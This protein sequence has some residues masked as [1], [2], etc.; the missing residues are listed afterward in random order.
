MCKVETKAAAAKG[1][2]WTPGSNSD[3]YM[4]EHSWKYRKPSKKN[5]FCSVHV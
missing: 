5:I 3:N 2:N 4:T 1:Q